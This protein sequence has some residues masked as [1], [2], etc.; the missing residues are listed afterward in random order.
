LVEGV[1]AAG[2]ADGLPERGHTRELCV[3]FAI[4]RNKSRT[5]ART[6]GEL[7][8]PRL[9]GTSLACLTLQ[10]DELRPLAHAERARTRRR[11]PA[12]CTRC[13]ACWLASCR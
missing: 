8:R 6:V 7:A 4:T 13:R 1:G 9:Y 12:W 11:G 10:W 3:S 2:R 5:R